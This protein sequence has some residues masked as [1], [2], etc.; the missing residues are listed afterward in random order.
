[1]RACTDLL[2]RLSRA[3]DTVFCGR[4]FIYLFQCFPLGDK[5]A[6]NSRGEYHI[7][8]V[9]VYD[10]RP[11]ARESANGDPVSMD[12][13]PQESDET[14]RPDQLPP[15]PTVQA[16]TEHSLPKENVEEQGEAKAS[17][18]PP[19]PRTL[20]TDELYPI[21]WSLQEYFAKPTSLFEPQNLKTFQAGLE[22]TLAKFKEV[23]QDQD[24][25][26]GT[27]SQEE[28][29]A[30]AKRKREDDEE[31]AVSSYNPKYLT[32]RDLFELEIRD[33]AFR[34]HV[35]V[36]ALILAE[37][38]LAQ[39]PKA[40]AR[41][42][43]LRNKNVIYDFTLD[44]AG[45]EWASRVRAEIAGYLQQG[46]EGKFYYRMVDTVLAR[47]KNWVHWKAENC[48][49]FQRPAIAP[50][51]F[52]TVRGEAQRATAP[53]R[54]RGAPMGALDLGFLAEQ[55]SA[56]ALERLKDPERSRVPDLQTF[57]RPLADSHFEVDM[58]KDESAREHAKDARAS[59]QWRALRV[60][61]KSRLA[62]F[63]PLDDTGQMKALFAAS[64]DPTVQETEDGAA[65]VPEDTP[66]ESGLQDHAAKDTGG[67]D[68]KAGDVSG[69]AGGVAT[70]PAMAGEDIAT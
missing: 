44:D 17:D 13:E 2:R 4:V 36:Q 55:D 39:T 45:V 54:L 49:P 61:S 7:E 15:P 67:S 64:K 69:P 11:P 42:Q 1:M 26:S 34:R 70:E 56:A 9:T 50:D 5:S 60:A 41:L 48:P 65:K 19:A 27:K 32:N 53:K 18:A 46:A 38:L 3:E 20:T 25:R 66:M 68:A 23:Q 59:Q 31:N 47:D 14:K 43:A 51:E 6:V 62:A 22:A 37:F 52:V 33:L 58:A 16:D 40:K 63:E 28:A 10:A 8:N 29:R 57:E 21:F 35:L 30:G 24:A 12:V